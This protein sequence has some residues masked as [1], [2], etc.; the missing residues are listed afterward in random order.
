MLLD[1]ANEILVQIYE[2][3]TSV[4]DVINLSLTCHRL[5]RLLPTSQRLPV[6]FLA[7]EA[8]FGPLVDITQLVTYNTSQPAHLMRHA[9]MSYSLLRQI[10]QVGRVAC[11]WEQ[12]FPS[13]KWKHNFADRRLLTSHERYRLRRAVYR[14]WLYTHAFHTRLNPRTTRTIRAV[15]LERAELLHNWSTRDLAEVE[16]VRN[17][18]RE[19]IQTRVCPSN[20]HVQ[21]KLKSAFPMFDTQAYYKFRHG[22]RSASIADDELFYT[23]RCLHADDGALTRLHSAIRNDFPFEGWGDEVLHYYVVEDM[24]KLD[25][26]QILWLYDNAHLKWQVETFTK[27][28]GEWFDNNGETFGQTLEWVMD[29]RGED[30]EDLRKAI[31][32]EILGVVTMAT[33][34]LQ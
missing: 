14:L 31:D 11:R 34:L 21:R 15:L 17:V 24:L 13:V 18:F 3:C 22:F 19:I 26:G 33:R 20:G 1:L 25:P 23:S 9:P 32:G 7:A 8:E 4:S 28:L 29:E 10:V 30:I 6:L 27:G 5:N 12:I 16:D 2:S